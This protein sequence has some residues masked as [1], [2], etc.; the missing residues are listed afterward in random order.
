M[1]VL[2]TCHA[3]SATPTPCSN[4]SL[5][6]DHAVTRLRLDHEPFQ[7]CG[8]S[9]EPDPV[10]ASCLGVQDLRPE[11]PKRLPV[12]FGERYPTETIDYLLEQVMG[13]RRD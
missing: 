13:V 4:A 6:N 3:R 11:H 12:K 10:P 1:C 7:E 5:G 9:L 2:V 8:F